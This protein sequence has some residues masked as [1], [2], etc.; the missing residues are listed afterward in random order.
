MYYTC[1]RG[2]RVWNFREQPAEPE[3]CKFKYRS[4]CGI[5]TS[6]AAARKFESNSWEVFYENR[7]SW[8]ADYAQ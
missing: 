1:S 4:R 7:G 2:R 3:R 6:S 8:Q 5:H